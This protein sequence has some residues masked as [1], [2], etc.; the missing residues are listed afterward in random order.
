MTFYS[1]GIPLRAGAGFKTAHFSSIDETRPD[2]GWFEVHPE[3]YMV[4]GGSFHHYLTAIRENYP[5]SLHGVGLSLGSVD[6][7]CKQHMSSLKKLIDRYEPDLVS[8]HLSWS[9]WQSTSL[10][11]LLPVPY[12][13]EAMNVFV[14][15]IDTAQ[16]ALGKTLLIENPSSYLA[17][18]DADYTES[19]FLVTLAKQSGA[20]ILLDVNNVYVSAMNHG[21][22]ANTYIEAI[23]AELVGEMHLA[24]HRINH[25]EHG[26]ICI[27][28]HGSAVADPVW[29]LYEFTLEHIG[30]KP[31][32]IEWDN[33]VPA[34]AVLYKEV[35]K[36]D[37]TISMI[38]SAGCLLI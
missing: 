36:V 15:N 1:S 26:A 9:R 11:D 37:Q 19:D 12:T 17:F 2:V 35:K 25:T 32:L 30:I 6:G 23:P 16:M 18:K 5:L 21:F 10:N 28:D 27:D 34:W 20:K 38:N 24:G 29:K 8:E 14:R 13:H 33:H 3:N 31:T 4:L 7:V 22:D